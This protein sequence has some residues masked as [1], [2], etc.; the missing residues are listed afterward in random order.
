MNI[1]EDEYA[2]WFLQRA[3]DHYEYTQDEKDVIHAIRTSKD[4]YSDQKIYFGVMLMD[5]GTEKIRVQNLQKRLALSYQGKDIEEYL[6]NIVRF[7]PKLGYVSVEAG[8]S[9]R[10][11][12]NDYSCHFTLPVEYDED[13]ESYFK[14][15][16]EIRDK[17]KQVLRIILVDAKKMRLL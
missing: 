11:E 7:N 6:D 2:D 1:K 12:N 16:K 17:L 4:I 9:R 15:A 13:T 3:E 5:Y 10:D 8:E 14:S